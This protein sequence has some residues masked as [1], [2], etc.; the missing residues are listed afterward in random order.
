MVADW[1]WI[2]GEGNVGGNGCA[3]F[4]SFCKAKQLL[5][6]NSQQSQRIWLA[7]IKVNQINQINTSKKQSLY[8]CFLTVAFSFTRV[9]WWS[10]YTSS[11]YSPSLKDRLDIKN[12]LI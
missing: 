7:L 8:F 1:W 5:S 12:I 2:V 9:A 6:Q 4:D 10:F 3:K 11:E